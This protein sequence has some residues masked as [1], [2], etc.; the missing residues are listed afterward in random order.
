MTTTSAPAAALTDATRSLRGVVGEMK[1]LTKELGR[2]LTTSAPVGALMVLA[3][4]ATTGPQRACRIAGSMD[5]DPSVVSRHI[6]T[7][8]DRGFL[9]RRTDADDRRAQEIDLTPHGL[10]V[11][12]EISAQVDDRVR[13]VLDSWSDDEIDQ[14][15]TLLRRLHHG[16][17]SAR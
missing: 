6:R 14:L 17:V 13:T 3:H 7:L 1:L 5:L 2:D 15:G 10:T 9:V 12:R 8:E 16:L 4:V 11:M